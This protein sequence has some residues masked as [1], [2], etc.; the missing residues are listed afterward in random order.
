MMDSSTL[1]YVRVVFE[2]LWSCDIFLV[3][4]LLTR[5]SL[6]AIHFFKGQAHGG[7]LPP[8]PSETSGGIEKGDSEDQD[9]D[10]PIAT[11]TYCIN[12]GKVA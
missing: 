8:A 5:H 11:W 9:L 6:T 4:S 3:V 10:T 2:R 12:C 7:P 1:R